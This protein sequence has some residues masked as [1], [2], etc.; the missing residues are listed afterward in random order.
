VCVIGLGLLGQLTVRLA[1]AV[2]CDVAGI[3]LRSW[4]V[5]RAR[6]SGA[7]AL[8]ERGEVSESMPYSSPRRLPHP[9]R[10]GDRRR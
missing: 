5:E 7:Y 10:R 8:V 1:Q 3:D 4:T 2:G 9:N 6:S